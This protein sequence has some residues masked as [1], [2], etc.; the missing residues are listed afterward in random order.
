MIEAIV[1]IP[2]RIP[3]GTI[4]QGERLHQHCAS[5]RQLISGRSIRVVPLTFYKVFSVWSGVRYEHTFVTDEPMSPTNLMTYQRWD[6]KVVSDNGGNILFPIS[7]KR[8]ST[9]GASTFLFSHCIDSLLS[10]Y[11]DNMPM[12]NMMNTGDDEWDEHSLMPFPRGE[13]H[14]YAEYQL[15]VFEPA[16]N[17]L[18]AQWK[19]S[20]MYDLSMHT[21]T[22]EH[23]SA[24]EDGIYEICSSL[25]PDTMFDYIDDMMMYECNQHSSPESLITPY[26][27]LDFPL[28]PIT[29][30]CVMSPT[31]ILSKQLRSHLTNTYNLERY[32]S[33]AYN[34]QNDAFTQE[35][36]SS[37]TAT[38][39]PIFDEIAELVCQL[40]DT[41]F[42]IKLTWDD[43][44]PVMSSIF[45]YNRQVISPV[46]KTYEQLYSCIRQ[47][48]LNKHVDPNAFD[49][50]IISKSWTDEVFVSCLRHRGQPVNFYLNL[51]WY[52][53]TSP[54]LINHE[55]FTV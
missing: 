23:P 52:H 26:V 20:D 28:D 13:V 35:A 8:I 27:Y 3:Y 11:R 53:L 4:L 55:F 5:G 14:S 49:D 42:Q 38:N 1:P 33:M 44:Y 30:W 16:L 50:V 43:V 22:P 10:G 40:P 19:L 29:Q 2:N 45:G 31:Y 21:M 15:H 54:S 37:T 25:N 24:T 17:T 47:K 9:Y 36:S 51:A 48:F 18:W 39:M 32:L 41:H 12:C 34:P 7:V 46:A 6:G